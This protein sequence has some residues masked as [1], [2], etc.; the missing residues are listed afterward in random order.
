MKTM[1]QKYKQQL[2]G[3]NTTQSIS[4]NAQLKH[5]CMSLCTCLD[6]RCVTVHTPW[7][8][9]HVSWCGSHGL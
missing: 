8:C 3:F 9:D 6:C 1:Q 5:Y 2:N 4:E 7:L